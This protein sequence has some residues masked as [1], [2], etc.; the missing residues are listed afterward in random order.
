LHEQNESSI[1]LAI[2]L[3][4]FAFTPAT[5]LIVSPLIGLLPGQCACVP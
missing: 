3:F 1:M 4:C 2:V 5:L